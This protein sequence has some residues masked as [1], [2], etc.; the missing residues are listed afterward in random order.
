MIKH[1]FSNSDFKDKRL[2]ERANFVLSA[3]T[4]AGSSVINRIFS[5]FAEK[6][7]A[8]RMINNEKITCASIT[9]A[10]KKTCQQ[11]VA[12]SNIFHVLCLQDTC[13]I[14]YD[15]HSQRM[16]K[17]GRKPGCVSNEEVGC[18]FHPT[19]AIDAETLM[20]CGFTSIKMWNREEGSK[21][22][23][24]RD[25]KKLSPEEKESFRWSESIENTREL[26][27]GKVD[28]TMLSDRESDVYEVLKRASSNVRIIVR[29]NQNRRIKNHGDK[30]HD[31]M[32]GLPSL[33][34]YEFMI[35]ASHGRKARLA[36]MEVRFTSVE[37]ENPA[38]AKADASVK[39]N[40][41]RVS[42]ANDSVPQGEEPI[43]WILLTNHEVNTVDQALQCVSWYKCRWF[44]EELFRLLKKK[45]FAI[46][47]IQLEDTKCLEKN[48][49]FAAYA[50]MRCIT[51]KHAFDNGDYYRRVP[52]YRCFS[53]DEIETAKLLQRKLNGKTSKQQNPY[54]SGSL[55]WMSWIVARLG[56]WSG[57][58]TQS[59]PGYTTFKSGLDKL[60]YQCEM[61][62]IMKNVYKG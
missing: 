35:P 21:N 46:E 36:R 55:A 39:L 34:T 59:R 18:F 54:Y 48:I 1:P 22:C 27:G 50:A 11:T 47:D 40:C 17:K 33:G 8:Y 37:L 29:S 61:Y 31:M 24:A 28:I 3:M 13:E 41:I 10:Y 52:A 12:S 26:L 25:Y 4:S 14:N 20:P 23:Y 60:Q 9:D 7:A 6:I 53:C 43:E 15:A 62:Q 16:H 56:C 51:L 49:L 30:L 58:I 57:Y 42:E 45:G 5:T 19:L 38:Y 44:I 2:S 32:R